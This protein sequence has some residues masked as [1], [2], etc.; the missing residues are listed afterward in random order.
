MSEPIIEVEFNAKSTSQGI[1]DALNIAQQHGTVTAEKTCKVVFHGIADPDLERLLNLV[2]HLKHSKVLVDGEACKPRQVTET[3]ACPH[4]PLCKGI[5]KHAR[6]GFLSLEDFM[7]NYKPRIQKDQLV[8]QSGSITHLSGF[9]EEKAENTYQLK[10]DLLRN[11]L[12]EETK[13]EAKFC[14]QYD[15]EKLEN[16]VNKMPG[17]LKVFS[18]GG[19]AIHGPARPP[20]TQKRREPRPCVSRMGKF[21]DAFYQAQITGQVLEY[22]LQKIFSGVFPEKI[23]APTA[24]LD[25]EGLLQTLFS[26]SEDDFPEFYLSLAQYAPE[27]KR[28]GYSKK[29]LE[30]AKKIQ[31]APDI[32]AEF[33][34]DIGKTFLKTKHVEEAIQILQEGAEACNND[35]VILERL[36]EIELQHD[37]PKEAVGYLKRVLEIAPEELEFIQT[38]EKYAALRE[39]PEYQALLKK[40]QNAQ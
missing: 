3:I 40:Y 39:V 29:A 28:I 10:K 9:L 26:L 2:G 33:Y 38:N 11:H 24:D 13:F 22:Y 7:L 27:E 25:P 5:C 34:L 21:V 20:S 30:F 19:M 12:L 17:T 8:I 6:V 16:L 1:E 37:R 15:A 35:F 18:L 23:A 31:M 14:P 36:V 4:K 32:L